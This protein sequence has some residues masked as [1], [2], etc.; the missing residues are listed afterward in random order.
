MSSPLPTPL[1]L[2][3]DPVSLVVFAIY[4]SLMLWELLLPARRLPPVRGWYLRGLAAFALFFFLSSYLPLLWGEYLAGLQ[5]FD[6]AHLPVW[7][8]AIVG[9][10]VYE[11][12]VYAWHRT[13]HGSTVLWRGF[14]QMHH[15]AERLDTYGAFWFSP[16]DMV[17]WTALSSLCLT[18]VVGLSPEAATMV[19]YATTFMAVFQHANVR[20]PRWLGY[21]I[22]RPESHSVHH[23]RGVHAWNYSDL[24]LFDIVFG[25]FR[26]PR[27]HALEQGLYDGAS[28]QVGS[29]LVF[30]D[31]LA[32]SAGRRR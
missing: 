11:A 27:N 21:I 4:G 30:R 15:S 8:G 12:G 24:P 18:L 32:T 16:L 9:V 14:H 3:L 17:G 10:L 25:T 7:A 28:A 31:L 1:Q 2:L 26:N 29:M 20:T 23:A 6:L 19:L 5:L 22:Q 13:M